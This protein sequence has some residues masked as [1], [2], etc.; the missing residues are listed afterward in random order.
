MTRR[1]A[2]LALCAVHAVLTWRA[3]L[4]PEDLLYEFGHEADLY[5]DGGDSYQSYDSYDYDDEI[6]YNINYY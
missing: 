4:E 6:N 1:C 3:G 2:D 5:S